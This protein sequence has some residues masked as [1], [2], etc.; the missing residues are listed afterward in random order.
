L[1]RLDGLPLKPKDGEGVIT[2]VIY[3]FGSKA[4]GTVRLASNDPKSKP[5]IDPAYFD[6]D[7]DLAVLAEG[8]RLAHEI[9]TEG[10]G[11]KDLIV[12]AWPKE[13]RHPTDINDWKEYIRTFAT[14]GCHPGGTCKM[15]PDNDL[16][17][18]V[19]SYLRVRNVEGLRVA[20]LSI[21]PLLNNGHTQA[22]AYAIGEKAAHMI[23]QDVHA[24]E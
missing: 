14:T 2:L 3:L 10:R 15:A 16:T 9:L 13:R 4:R 20:D 23:L 11:T 19:D 1:N 21:L 12:G 7:L 18:V 8:C 6:N 22:I 5:I 17:G 24:Q